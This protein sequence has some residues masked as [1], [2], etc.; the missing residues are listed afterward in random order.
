MVRLRP[1]EVVDDRVLLAR[2]QA[3]IVRLKQ[4]LRQALD[5]T[6]RA[7]AG[8]KE[9]VEAAEKISL[10]VGSDL[11]SAVKTI[12]S[13][14]APQNIDDSLETAP[15]KTAGPGDS[16]DA[17][18]SGNAAALTAASQRRQVARLIADSEHL[19]EENERLKTEVQRLVD[20]EHQRQ[21]QKKRHY[22]RGRSSSFGSRSLAAGRLSFSPSPVDW[23][24][25]YA[26]AA[27]AARRRRRPGSSSRSS[28]LG[29][30]SRGAS[31]R[32]RS[33]SPS[34]TATRASIPRFRRHAFQEEEGEV[35]LPERAMDL[36][37]EKLREIL[38]E[39]GD[40]E[41][42]EMSG[43]IQRKEDPNEVKAVRELE[44]FRSELDRLA[45]ADRSEQR[46]TGEAM[47]SARHVNEKDIVVQEAEESQRLE[48]VMFEAQ[49]RERQRVREERARLSAARAERLALEAQL[50]S[51]N[52]VTHGD[53]A[54]LSVNPETAEP[55]TTTPQATIRK[56][57]GEGHTVDEPLFSR[58]V[59]TN[60]RRAPLADVEVS[61]TFGDK[62][63]DRVEGRTDA[64]EHTEPCR[65]DT[66]LNAAATAVTTAE[67]DENTQE[68]NVTNKVNISLSEQCRTAIASASQLPVARQTGW[69]TPPP[70]PQRSPSRRRPVTSAGNALART[71]SWRSWKKDRGGS[72]SPTRVSDSMHTLGTSSKARK[73]RAKW[74]RQQHQKG[75]PTVP[76]EHKQVDAPESAASLPRNREAKLT[77]LYTAYP[78]SHVSSPGGSG[79]A[80]RKPGGSQVATAGDKNGGSAVPSNKFQERDRPCTS[81]PDVDVDDAKIRVKSASKGRARLAYSVADRGLRLTVRCCTCVGDFDPNM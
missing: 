28:I 2:A 18:G 32:A 11:H 54:D 51:L 43:V 45:S 20:C 34:V 25:R 62:I 42:S 8:P 52:A 68:E 48:D 30:N 60:G 5:N 79:L 59:P 61:P 40:G 55:P 9:S 50:A 71:R 4:L 13:T 14:R 70:R 19:R 16:P 58:R 77:A 33:A 64:G 37:T 81:D 66:T 56:Y 17:V 47:A 7:D 10:G 6:L 36:S 63:D 15:E 67:R 74:K 31:S 1:N 76:F 3:E 57:A 80:T 26:D 24:V 69:T 65:R 75:S 39:E 53:S 49:G 21:K 44:R 22:R 72:Q 41:G 12:T 38:G 27:E 46:R 29:A 73:S 23:G 35:T 78:L